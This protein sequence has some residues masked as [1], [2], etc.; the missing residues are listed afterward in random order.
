MLT[1]LAF[2]FTLAVLIV[3][4]EY[5]HYIVARWC[6]VRVLTFAI[7]FGRALYTRKMRNGTDFVIAAFPL[8]GYVKMLD[9]HEA[10]VDGDDLA[11]AYNRQSVWKR[12]AIVVAGPLA[13]LLLAVVLYWVLFM[14]GVTD[15]KPILGEVAQGTPA[16]QASIKA[17]ET[18]TRVGGKP[19]ISWQALHWE[20]MQHALKGDVVEIEAK[21]GADETHLHRVD[22][23]ALKTGDFDE[24][25]FER[26]GFVPARPPM[27][28]RVGE[29]VPG[30]V[31][32]LAGMRVGD[33][34]TAVDGVPVSD[35][36]A[37]VQ[38]VRANA[39][40]PLMVVLDRDGKAVSVKL[41]P[42]AE[43]EAGRTIGRIGA[44][45]RM[46]EEEWKMFLVEIKYPPVKALERALAKTWDT[47]MVSLKMLG[48]MLMGAISWKGV[49]GPV[50]IA[51]LA[52][53][54]AQLGLQT[55]IGFLALIS[56]SLGVLNLLP[57]PVLDGGHL[58]Y[59]IVE[60]IKGS[61]LS[62]RVMAMGQ[63]VGIALLGLLMTIA[64][65]NDITRLLTS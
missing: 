15:M 30:G 59:H 14:S 20:L 47:S 53:Q 37:F 40:K 13:N 62:E 65:Y 4:H 48:S 61:P 5:G 12:S 36:N 3:V 35:W 32:S 11:Y 60:V 51:T 16:A 22:F 19:I 10:P 49:S 63:R 25:M 39:S 46:G 64:L 58:M 21:S 23:R 29:I 57:V 38:I 33:L 54:T 42:A 18:V 24:A 7:G 28:A 34:I 31:A 41:T 8:G 52:G 44:A 1:L 45:Y 50:T 6:G 2:V 43:H 55:Y 27:P 17:G 9:E 26:T 56:V